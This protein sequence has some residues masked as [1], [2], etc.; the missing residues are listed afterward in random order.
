MKEK[1]RKSK[2]IYRISGLHRMKEEIK[3]ESLF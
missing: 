2:E 1:G 3:K